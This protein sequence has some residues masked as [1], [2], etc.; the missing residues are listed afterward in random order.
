[1]LNPFKFLEKLLYFVRDTAWSIP[2]LLAP[3]SKSIDSFKKAY[4]TAIPYSHFILGIVIFIVMTGLFSLN[5]KSRILGPTKTIVEGVIMG[6]DQAGRIQRINKVNPLLPTNIQLEKDLTELIYEPLIKYE[7][8]EAD[9]EKAEPKIKNILAS[10]V[11]KIKQGSDYQF[12][13]KRGVL[14]HDG[15]EFTADDVIAT[16]NFVSKLSKNDNAYIRAIKQMQWEKVDKYAVRLCT[17]GSDSQANCNENND[18]P[19]FSNFLELISI[20]MLPEHKLS[21][22]QDS[23]IESFDADIFRSPLGTGKYRFHSALNDSIT[24]VKNENYIY[25][26]NGKQPV[27][28]QIIFKYYKNLDD[29]AEAILNGEIHSLVSTSVEFK[30]EIEDSA[31]IAIHTSPVLDNQ[32]WALYFNL[33]KDPNGNSIGASFLQDLK[34]RQAISL[35]VDRQE[36]MDEALLGAGDE[37]FGPISKRSYYFNDQVNWLRFNKARAINLL[38]ETE[39]RIKSGDRYRTNSQG[40]V[41][42]FSL[43]FVNSFDRQNIARVIQKNLADIGIRAIIDRREQPGQDTSS[44]APAGWNL[45]ELNKE[46]LAP[47]SFDV[48][49]YGM[50]TF[51]DPDRYEL[52]HSSQQN[53]PGLNI[54]SYS[55]SVETVRPR[56]NRQEGE[57]SLERL[58]KVDRLLE[59]TRSFDPEEA[60]DERKKNYDEFQQLLSDDAPVVFLFNPKFIYYTNTLIKDVSLS[61]VASVEERFLNIQEWRM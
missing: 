55:G 47:R 50:N 59:T 8:D 4:E 60:R 35:A 34:V 51:I 13:L 30:S 21:E 25:G 53:D 36:I 57:S 43:Y 32:Y 1:M 23:L 29:A 9:K 48:L 27:I 16:L 24:L 45:D 19:I 11:I 22:I 33:K 56:E 12:N 61:N 15:I 38:D 14:W 5:I 54:S 20:K 39:W 41:M 28:E 42:E 17:K 18:N 49:L 44:S 40:D 26:I 58:P 10:E 6:V 52:F 3:N 7:Y 46:V 31:N 37:A 2:D